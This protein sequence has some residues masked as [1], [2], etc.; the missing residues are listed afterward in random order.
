MSLAL[1]LAAQLAAV[2]PS[3]AEAKARA[4][5]YEALLLPRDSQALVEAQTGALEAALRVCGP[6]PKRGEPVVL[7]LRVGKDG[8]P[9][10]SWRKGESEFAICIERE[11]VRAPLPV[12]GGKAFYTSY[13]LSF[14]Q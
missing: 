12:A 1:L 4:D 3:F 5:E 2:E 13:E 14:S 6:A 7:V 11:L 10:S 9:E 8:S